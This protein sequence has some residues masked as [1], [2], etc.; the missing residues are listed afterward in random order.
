MGEEEEVQD[1]QQVA[2]VEK[3]TMDLEMSRQ[4]VPEPSDGELYL[5]KMPDFMAIDPH[6]WVHSNFQPPTTDHHSD[7]APSAAFSAFNVA[8]S[9]I[10]WRHSPSDPSKLQ[11]NARILRWSD[12]SLTLQLGSQPAVQY[13]IEGNP[14]APPQRN[15]LKPTPV[16]QTTTSTSKGGRQGDG[17]VPG[18]RY[19]FS[20]DAFTYLVAP[21]SSTETLRVT[22]KVTAGLSMRRPNDAQDDAIEILQAALAK[23]A[24]ASKVNG[25]GNGPADLEL[26]E[27][28][29]EKKRQEAEK[30]MRQKAALQ[31]RAQA[32]QERNAERE[33]RVTGRLG[34]GGSRGGLNASM[35]E[36][37]DG[38]GTTR[39]RR[40]G[41]TPKKSRRR[42]NS[43]YSDDEDFGRKRFAT[44]EDEYDEEDGFLVGSD[45][46]EEVEEEEEQDPDDGIVEV[47]RERRER[48]PK[49]ERERGDV[50]GVGGEEDAEGE[51]DEEVQATRVKRRRIVDE[52]DDEEE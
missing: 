20:K 15:P 44:R 42:R 37:E 48:T 22:H 10:R 52:D 6:A 41:A 2:A 30:A 25:V 23:A 32:A 46:E 3:V 5:L 51:E 18:E 12:G 49:R 43:I 14:L 13:E 40:T 27:E 29:P 38:M 33:R 35:L 26:I 50:G 31:K 4:P 16:S 34:G 9:T 28:D 7:K 45:E 47:P 1:E 11:S 8:T 21:M 39:G 36:D 24:N 17:T 19:D